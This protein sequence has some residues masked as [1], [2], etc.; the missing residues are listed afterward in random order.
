MF[1]NAKQSLTFWCNEQPS[2]PKWV[3]S[4]RPRTSDQQNQ[5][6]DE[7]IVTIPAHKNVRHLNKTGSSAKV[8]RFNHTF[9]YIL[10]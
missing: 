2:A 10:H 9:G 6:L 5:M 4:V 1:I 3:V 8:R 7:V